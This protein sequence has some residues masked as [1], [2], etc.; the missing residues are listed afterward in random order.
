MAL[1]VEEIRENAPRRAL[2]VGVL[3]FLLLA[4]AIAASAE[5]TRVRLRDGS[6]AT[7]KPGEDL[8]LEA[9]PRPGEGL[10]GFARRF[11]GSTQVAGKIAERNGGVEYLLRDV[12][13]EVPFSLL[14]PEY[15]QRI[16]RSLFAE[17]DARGDGWIHRARLDPE[18]GGGESLWSIALWFTGRGE[19]YVAI[20]DANR[21]GLVEDEVAPSQ[22]VLIPAR[23]LRPTFRV[24]LPEESPYYLTYDRDGDGEYAVYR[25]K[26]GEALYS[27]VVVRFNGSVFADDVNEIAAEI[28]SRSGIDDVTDIPVGYEVKVPFD[29]LLPEFLPAGHPRRSEYEAGLIES[30]QYRN[31]VQARSLEGVTI[32]LDAG[33]GGRDVGASF[34]DVW[35]SVYVYDIMARVK[36]QLEQ[37]TAARVYATTMDGNGHGVT[38]Q[39]K[40]P[41]SRGHRVLTT[42]NYAIEDSRIGAN[43]RWYL[44]NS[45]YRKA[46]NGDD[47]K[48]RLPVDPRRLAPPEPARRDGLHPRRQ[49]AQELL[50]QVRQRLR[51]PRR[52][53]R[54]PQ[55]ELLPQTAHPQRGPIE[56][57]GP[58]PDR[59]LR[60][61]RPR[62]P[63]GQ[64]GPRQDHPPKKRLGP[65][66]PPLQPRPGL[67][68]ARGLQPGQPR[69]PQ[70]DSDGGV[71]AAG[72]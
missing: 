1:S 60:Q 24:L 59:G 29:L 14:L 72:E 28:A 30:A 51:R 18:T 55:G 6:V 32:I 69:R 17:D 56:R 52:V 39:D 62:R 43:L 46:V 3:A 33:H 16:A 15:R 22:S 23:L 20:R 45:I 65:R 47:Q 25:L 71:P 57:P 12:R 10:L 31:V 35:E 21:E 67:R 40:L 26:R 27:S 11:C 70:A 42:P 64:T 41:R 38:S 50:Q 68:A 54:V 66:G 19:N 58:P 61:P 4:V 7:L 49:V 37:T 5:T 2:C 36:R 63:R 13:Y 44:S 53:P 9:T 34:G 48:D 8:L